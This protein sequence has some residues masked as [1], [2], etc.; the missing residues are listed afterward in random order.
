MTFGSME[1]DHSSGGLAGR[2][3]ALASGALIGALSLVF[4]ISYAAVLFTGPLE[5]FR[6]HAIAVGIASAIIFAAVGAFSASSPGD[7]WT[8]QAAPVALMALGTAE[9]QAA[10]PEAS[11]DVLLSTTLLFLTCSSLGAG[12]LMLAVGVAGVGQL[13][14][15]VPYPVIGGFLAAT[16]L[17]LVIRA[18]ALALP[19]GPHAD[20]DFYLD[21][22]RAWSPF[23]GAGACL[24]LLSRRVPPALLLLAA[25]GLFI[26]GFWAFLAA[27]GI[28][29]AEARASGLLLD[30][31]VGGAVPLSSSW[32]ARLAAPDLAAVA[33]QWEVLVA[34]AGLSFL[35]LLMNSSALELESDAS[36]DLNQD[37][38]RGGVA[39]LLSGAA[40][41]FVGYPSVSM[42]RF[43]RHIA[44]GSSG[45]GHLGVLALLAAASLGGMAAMS[46]LPVGL[47]V[48]ML[49]YIGTDILHRWL[50]VGYREM[51]M[52]DYA[53]VLVIL[54]V[55]LLSDFVAAIVVGMIAA[56]LRFAAAYSRVD[57][58]RSGLTGRLR[59]SPVER[60]EADIEI[61]TSRGAETMVFELQGF[62][63]FG[64]A[65]ELYDRI[66]K[67][68]EGGN[69]QVRHL[70]IDFRRVEGM[71]ISTAFVFSRLLRYAKRKRISVIYTHLRGGEVDRLERS[72]A[73]RGAAV[74]P[75]LQ[76]GLA[77][78]EDGI[79][80][81][82]PDEGRPPHPLDVLFARALAA[83]HP[84]ARE[85]ERLGAG[86][87]VFA[88][89]EASDAL[90][91]LEE[92]RLSALV[93]HAGGDP[94]RVAGFL[95]G[96][97]VGE[98]GFFTGL[99][100]TATLMSDTEVRLSRVD[101]EAL[102]RVTEVA[103]DI[104][105]EFHAHLNRLL[106][107]RLGRTTALFVAMDV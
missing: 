37:L 76:D 106:A 7:W 50:I 75:A 11:T 23:V 87:V 62:L 59:L 88:Q 90:I 77:E 44:P 95:P 101:R 104:A 74:R 97:V 93:R 34:V 78:I 26:A 84:L 43:G 51:P 39:N 65:N 91:F 68:I 72:G 19:A 35:G 27:R 12:L 32:E 94:I 22:W 98:I 20:F 29:V 31:A 61:L 24:A 46:L 30:M 71:D 73:L 103:P 107:K 81:E 86:Q 33:A 80:L 67:R 100:R 4:T 85:S 54:G 45:L 6:D 10:I 25:T 57:V 53:I 2:S 49:A 58:V 92:G 21:H 8:N 36:R 102:R 69:A 96:S 66:V 105:A 1:D 64:T 41:G 14:K 70:V 82:A 13:A 42:A 17:F 28:T 56:T 40:G 60:S 15:F 5:P 79:L 3:R 38:R 83:G 16:G 63:F 18:A 9:L 99:P 47:F 55:T 52:L 48:V 89:G